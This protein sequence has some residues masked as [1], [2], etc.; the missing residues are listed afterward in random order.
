M[1]YCLLRGAFTPRTFWT[2][3]IGQVLLDNC[4]ADCTVLVNWACVA[5]TYDGPRDLARNNTIPLVALNCLQVPISAKVLKQETWKW[6]TADPPKLAQQATTLEAQ[7]LQQN[8]AM[9]QLL[10]QQ[11]DKA[12]AAHAAAATPKMVSAVY[13]KRSAC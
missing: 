1:A 8:M 5:F 10:Q 2:D 3:V 12:T 9:S 13:P 4:A 6:V 11:V 7:F